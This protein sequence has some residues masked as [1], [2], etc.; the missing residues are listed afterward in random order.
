M[1]RPPDMRVQIEDF[2]GE[3][4]N[5]DPSDIPRGSSRVQINLV[6]RVMGELNVR[7]GFRTAAFDTQTLIPSLL[8]D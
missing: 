1:A 4:N 2:P 5:V 7:R 6:S 8:G 3:V